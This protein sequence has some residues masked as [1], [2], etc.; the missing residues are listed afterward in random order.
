LFAK[1]KELEMTTA[2]CIS[3]G[4]EIK[5]SAQPKMGV[6]VTCSECKAELEVVWLD[7]VELDWPFD[8]EDYYEEDEEYYDEE[9]D[10]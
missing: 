9:E 3:C 4:N 1:Q 6:Q 8:E 2:E 7:P 5:F 10:Y